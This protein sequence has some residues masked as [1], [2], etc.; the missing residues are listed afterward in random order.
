VPVEEGDL[1][2]QNKKKANLK[3]FSYFR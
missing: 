3:L 1:F 2:D